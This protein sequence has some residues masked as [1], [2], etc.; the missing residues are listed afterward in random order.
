LGKS[1]KSWKFFP[2]LLNKSLDLI[3]FQEN[4]QKIDSKCLDDLTLKKILPKI[5]SSDLQKLE[6]IYQKWKQKI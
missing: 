5:F 2:H 3:E 6:T 1:L 4:Q